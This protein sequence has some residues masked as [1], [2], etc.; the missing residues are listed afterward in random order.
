MHVHPA[1]RRIK[2]RPIDYISMASNKHGPIDHMPDTNLRCSE[3]CCG[4]P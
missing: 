4:M 2:F 1:G 3:M